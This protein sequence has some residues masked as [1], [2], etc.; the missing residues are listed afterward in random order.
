MANDRSRILVDHLREMAEAAQYRD[1]S[2]QDLIQAFAGGNSEAAFGALVRRHGPMVLGVCRRVLGNE[3][4]AED[5]YQATF[6]VLARKARHLQS[7]ELVGNW[8]YGVARRTA[9]KARVARSRR[10]GHEEAAPVRDSK[11][12]VAE[13]TVQEAQQVVDRELENLPA[14]FRAPVVLCCLEGLARDEAAKQLGW[15]VALVKSRLEQGRELLRRRLGGRGLTL[16]AGFLALGLLAGTAQ[17]AVRPTLA[18][19]TVKAGT[20]VAA[21]GSAVGLVSQ[22]AIHWSDAML[23]SMFWSSFKTWTVAAVLTV[24]LGAGLAA[25]YAGVQ[26]ARKDPE[27]WAQ[28]NPVAATAP[29]QPGAP[30]QPAP[31]LTADI[32]K[33]W[34]QAEVVIFAKLD[35]VQAGPVG[36]SEPPVYSHTLYLQVQKALRGSVKADDKLTV[37]HSIRQKNAPTFPVGKDC[38]VALKQVKGQWTVTAIAEATDELKAQVEVASAVPMGWTMEKDHLVSP[39]AKLGKNAWPAGA[40]GA[41]RLVCAETGRPALLVGPG[42][43]LSVEAVKP[44]VEVKYANP[45]GDGEYKITVKNTS[46]KAVTIPALLS[47]GQ[48]I[49]WDESL[50]ILC[51]GKVYAAPG[52]AGVKQPPQAV[53][54]KA[55]EAVSTVVNILRLQG[56][57]WPRG[58]YRIEFQFALGE[59]SATQSFYYTSK[60]H[61]PLRE[62]LNS[63]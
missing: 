48:K 46:D 2:D 24:L 17:A 56:P 22:Q 5:A 55:G 30:V 32:L 11:D 15:P 40:K 49:L 16:P 39:W 19:A 62:K 3:Q 6:L 60:H 54:L 34:G 35:K 38:V 43:E 37:H 31:K 1:T 8:L 33:M 21:G 59:K 58:G 36:L 20:L 41:G 53:T 7:R 9:Q 47:D 28:P 45:D 57:D 4:D 10:S 18:G 29:E 51:Q 50:V 27:E 26:G 42:V 61:D 23:R 52:A 12:P 63:K 25:A 44:A 14:K 13:L